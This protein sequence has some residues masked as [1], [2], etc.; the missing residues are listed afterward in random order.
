MKF[1]ECVFLVALFAAGCTK[2]LPVPIEQE[3][4]VFNISECVETFRFLESKLLFERKVVC[5][6]TSVPLYIGVKD[7]PK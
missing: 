3:R 7:L 5:S 4:E 1:K 6:R 2:S